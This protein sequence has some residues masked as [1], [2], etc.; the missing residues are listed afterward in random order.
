MSATVAVLGGQ[1]N[2]PGDAADCATV[3]GSRTAPTDGASSPALRLIEAL[4]ER[5]K[6]LGYI[7][8]EMERHRCRL[9][10]MAYRCR[11]KELFFALLGEA[12]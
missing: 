3:G 5:A 12:A 7:A 10:R 2:P 8:C 1:P 4:E 9:L 11:D 6:T